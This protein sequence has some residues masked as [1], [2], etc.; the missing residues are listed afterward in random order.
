MTDPERFVADILEKAGAEP[1]TERVSP[2]FANERIAEK[3]SRFTDPKQRE[4]ME[5]LDQ[6]LRDRDVPPGVR[7][8][9]IS[10]VAHLSRIAEGTLRERQERAG[11]R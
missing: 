8:H 10:A 5:S 4:G 7:L 3:V 6:T 2:E 9:L 11:A 1:E